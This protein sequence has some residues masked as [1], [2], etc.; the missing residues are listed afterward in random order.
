MG[1]RTIFDIISQRFIG[2]E[3]DLLIFS[4]KKDKKQE[5]SLGITD[6]PLLL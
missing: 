4:D 1:Q 2:M 5:V 3:Q 6:F